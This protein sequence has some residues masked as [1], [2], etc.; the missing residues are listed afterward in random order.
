MPKV[1]DFE[2]SAGVKDFFLGKI[3]TCNYTIDHGLQEAHSHCGVYVRDPAMPQRRKGGYICFFFLPA[4]FSKINIYCFCK[5][6]SNNKRR[7]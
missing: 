1:L 6:I 5:N 7:V 2:N 3:S 4:M